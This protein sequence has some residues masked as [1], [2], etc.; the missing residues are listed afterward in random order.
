MF[1]TCL[2]CREWWSWYTNMFADMGSEFRNEICARMTFALMVINNYIMY[3]SMVILI[4]WE[5]YLILFLVK[6]S[7]G[8]HSFDSPCITEYIVLYKR[9]NAGHEW[10]S[11]H[12]R[13]VL[14]LFPN[15]IIGFVLFYFIEVKLVFLAWSTEP[16][17]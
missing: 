2:Y 6:S 7:L 4:W 5:I 3:E 16:R 9:G 13:W 8:E 14:T 1:I 17:S 10:Y 15:K 11:L 12:L